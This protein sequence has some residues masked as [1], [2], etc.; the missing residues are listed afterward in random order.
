MAD[1]NSYIA[2]MLSG[3]NLSDRSLEEIIAQL[4]G[5]NNPSSFAY[6]PMEQ[7]Q[8]NIPTLLT[9]ADYLSKT[10]AEGYQYNYDDILK[11]MNDA[12]ELQWIATQNAQRDAEDAYYR[13]LAANQESAAD[14]IKNQAAQAIQA[15]ITKGLQNANLLST[16]LGTSQNGVQGLQEL[17]NQRYQAGLDYA[18]SLG[19]N[20]NS[21]RAEAN[22]A[23]ETLL[24]NIRQLYNDD[25][26]RETAELEYNASVGETNA[27]AAAQKYASDTN[28]ASGVLNNAANIKNQ[29]TAAL[30]QIAAQAANSAA[31]DNYSAAYAA[32]SSGAGS[33]SYASSSSYVDTSANDIPSQESQAYIR[34]QGGVVATPTNPNSATGQYLTQLAQAAQTTTSKKD[35]VAKVTGS[36]GTSSVNTNT[37]VSG[38][39][40]VAQTR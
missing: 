15:G 3:V 39:K 2:Q 10:G 22:A 29:L 37:Q 26:Q 18:T 5:Q 25:I 23:L 27:N 30:A 40:K 36:G 16:I 32:K 35:A 38:T 14:T 4:G 31:Q 8:V 28:Y 7:M 21:A 20:V 9:I 12:T 13:G 11:A 33:G 19:N 34:A 6:T 24:G 17:V 1:T